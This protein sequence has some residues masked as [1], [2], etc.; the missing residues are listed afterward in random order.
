MTVLSITITD[1]S[2][3][4]Q[5]SEVGY[6]RNVLKL[7]EQHLGSRQGTQTGAQNVLGVS[8]TGVPNT[9]VASYTY[10]AS[11]SKP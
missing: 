9:V 1:P 8:S 3:D 6:L 2:F 10:T 11:A 4:K 5:S 7:I